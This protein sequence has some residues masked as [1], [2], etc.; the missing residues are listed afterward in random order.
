MVPIAI[1]IFESE[2]ELLTDIILAAREAFKEVLAEKEPTDIPSDEKPSQTPYEVV[3]DVIRD[4][5]SPAQSFQRMQIL[6]RQ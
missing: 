1:K 3:V 2:G 5:E 4:E 6:Q